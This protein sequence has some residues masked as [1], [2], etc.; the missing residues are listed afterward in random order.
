[1]SGSCLACLVDCNSER[2]KI[3]GRRGRLA[4]ADLRSLERINAPTVQLGDDQ[5]AISLDVEE[6]A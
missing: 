2:L 4:L 6:E 3:L 1:M 5:K